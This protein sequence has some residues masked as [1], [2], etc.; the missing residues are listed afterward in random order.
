MQ[1]IKTHALTGRSDRVNALI[2]YEN[3]GRFQVAHQ[4]TR[5]SVYDLKAGDYPDRAGAELA[6]DIEANRQDAIA[7][8]ASEPDN[9]DR[10]W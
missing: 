6:F 3:Y 7:V 10:F 9:G 1:V 4:T 8:M 5:G 2:L